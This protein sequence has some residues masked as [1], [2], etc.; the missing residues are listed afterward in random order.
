MKTT[1]ESRRWRRCTMVAMVAESATAARSGVVM[2]GEPRGERRAEKSGGRLTSLFNA[3][4]AWTRWRGVV[5]RHIDFLMDCGLRLVSWC[6]L[7]SGTLDPLQ[8]DFSV[9]KWCKQ[10]YSHKD[11]QS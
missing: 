3:L 9:E 7:V 6:G 10:T 5:G 11:L 8:L 1:I 2:G 4:A